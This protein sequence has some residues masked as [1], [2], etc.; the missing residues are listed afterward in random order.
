LLKFFAGFKFLQWLYT[1][2]SITRLSWKANSYFYYHLCHLEQIRHVVDVDCGPLVDV[3]LDCGP[4]V[5]DV[6]CG[7]L[8]VDVDCGPL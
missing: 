3:D 2:N 4:F 1:S 8:V 7:P 5:V 6:D